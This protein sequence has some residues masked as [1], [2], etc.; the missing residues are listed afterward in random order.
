MR[1]RPVK[2]ELRAGDKLG[3]Y[4]LEDKRGEGAM[5]CVFRARR[6]DSEEIVALKVIRAELADDAHFRR[7]FLQEAR[8]ASAVSHPHLVQ[9][10]DAGEVDGRQYLA[11]RFVRGRALE[12]HIREDGPLRVSEIMRIAVEIGAAIDAVHAAGLLHRD[13]KTSNI[14]LDDDRDR[15]AAL[16]DFGLAK[17][18]GYETL[19]RP[20]QM[21]GTLDYL[22]PERIRGEEASAASDIYGLGCALFECVAGLPPFA[23]GGAPMA[24][25]FGHL[26]TEPRNPCAGRADMPVAF[27]SALNAALA[28]DPDARPRSARCYGDLL[29]DA[30]AG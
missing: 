11:M 2:A 29:R 22:A 1:P 28:K 19:T 14:M 8:A 12:Q 21:L 24:A 9:V 3:S 15:A 18:A 17:G 25:A 30:C 27:G 10:L 26:E 20:G 13:I 6:A 5:G 16:T 4:R 7:R 23:S